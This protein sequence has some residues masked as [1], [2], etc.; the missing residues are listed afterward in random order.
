MAAKNTRKRTYD[1]AFLKLGFMEV[2]GKPKCVVCE[3]VLSKESLKKNKLLRHLETNHPAC[4]DKPIEYF[5]SKL[6]ALSS[7]ANVMKAF[8][9]VNKSAVYASYLASYEIAKQ[10]KAHTILL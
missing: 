10:K 2:N 8:T 3:K 9:T 7:Q 6:Q 4:V 1:E 5:R